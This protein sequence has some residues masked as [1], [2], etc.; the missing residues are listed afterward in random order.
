MCC[1]PRR[2]KPA[3]ANPWDADAW[4]GRHL[5]R[6]RPIISSPF[7]LWQA[8]IPFGKVGC[9]ESEQRS[10]LDRGIILDNGK[11]TIAT[12]P[13]DAEPNRIIT[14]PRNPIAPFL[15]TLVLTALFAALMAHSW[16]A[17]GVMVVM[18]LALTAYW[19]WPRG[20]KVAVQAGRGTA[21]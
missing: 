5:R 16:I 21:A 8:V 4:N 15:L 20:M 2:G 3:G 6:R 12:T 10:I 18:S 14:M 13:L 7:P 17:V 9:E 11:E 1:E 19:L